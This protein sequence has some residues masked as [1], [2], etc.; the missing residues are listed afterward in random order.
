VVRQGCRVADSTIG[1]RVE[2]LDSCLITDS[3]IGAGST[4]GPSAHLRDQTR[5]GENCRIGNFVE[6]KKSTVGNDTIAAHLAYLGDAII[7]ANVNIGAGAITCNFDGLRKNVTIIEDDA[8]VGSDAQLIAPVRVGK[9]AFVAAGSCI[10]KD[11]PPGA[12]AISRGRQ[13]NKPGGAE[14]RKKGSR[15]GND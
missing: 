8:F 13:I 3:E 12:L 4:I 10:T 7:G 1:A 5:V 15:K 14:G 2:I 6:I 11:V 9:G